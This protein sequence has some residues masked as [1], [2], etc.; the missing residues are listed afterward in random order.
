M[1]DLVAKWEDYIKCQE[2]DLADY[3]HDLDILYDPF[4]GLS[5]M[6][7]RGLFA[8][9]QPGGFGNQPGG[10]GSQPGSFG[11]QP[12]GFGNQPG[13]FGTGSGMDRPY[14]QSAFA[15]APSQVVGGYRQSSPMPMQKPF[16]QSFQPFSRNSDFLSFY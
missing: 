9:S 13:G 1:Q 8:T 4:Q 3:Q 15:P 16:E 10:F 2:D 7:Q 11:N 14:A 5:K 12:G 6:Q